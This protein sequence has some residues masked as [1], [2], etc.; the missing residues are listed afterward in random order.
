MA[1]SVYSKDNSC[2]STNIAYKQMKWKCGIPLQY[3]CHKV[4]TGRAGVCEIQHSL[5]ETAED[6]SPVPPK[7][8]IKYL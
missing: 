8:K 1:F 7:E 4:G 2:L 5:V 6:Y 3:H